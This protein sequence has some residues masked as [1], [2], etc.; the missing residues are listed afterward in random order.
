MKLSLL[1]AVA[2]QADFR[3]QGCGTKVEWGVTTAYKDDVNDHVCLT[4][5]NIVQETPLETVNE[6]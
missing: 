6:V 5:G 4:C 1:F 3:C 2:S